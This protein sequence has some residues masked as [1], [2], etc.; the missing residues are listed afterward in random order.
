MAQTT[1]LPD[2]SRLHLLGLSADE[3]SITAEANDYRS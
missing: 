3:A 2:P 1:I